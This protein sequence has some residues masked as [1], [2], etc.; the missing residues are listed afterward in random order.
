MSIFFTA[1]RGFALKCYLIKPFRKDQQVSLE[2]KIFNARLSHA[3]QIIE[4]AFGV[5]TRKWSIFENHVNFKLHNKEIVILACVLKRQLF[6]KLI[7]SG[8]LPPE[9]SFFDLKS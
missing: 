9:K 4:Y 8:A 1:D 3:R 6:P 5:V 7:F 2:N